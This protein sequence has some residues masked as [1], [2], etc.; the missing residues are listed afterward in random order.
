MTATGFSLEE[1][2]AI[3][4]FLRSCTVPLV[5]EADD[6]LGL[7]GTSAF[8]KFKQ[9]GLCLVTAAHVLEGGQDYLK[10]LAVPMKSC[11]QF[12]TL[13]SLKAYWPKPNE[14]DAAVVLLE[15]ADF[16]DRVEKNWRILNEDNVA[17]NS[18]MTSRFIVAG[19]P[20]QT[21][22]KHGGFAD[23]AFTQIYTERYAGPAIDN[24]SNQD[25]LLAYSKSAQG[26]DGETSDTPDLK[27]LSGAPVWAISDRTDGLWAPEKCLKII[28]VQDAFWHSTYI[29]A[30]PWDLV[31]EVLRQIPAHSWGQQI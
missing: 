26:I 12:I 3:E 18:R 10:G 2:Q 9:R 23:K 14:M 11:K 24:H 13:G 15:D 4:E 28:G 21:V 29:A 5:Y 27:G 20:R 17:R 31:C 7:A 25:I 6:R 8:F 1:V 19:Y 22:A 16:A 30:K